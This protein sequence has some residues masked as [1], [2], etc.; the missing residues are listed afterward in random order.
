MF[1]KNKTFP[2][3]C[4]DCWWS[5]KLNAKQYGIDYNPDLPFFDQFYSFSKNVPFP[6][7]IG[8]RNIN[9]HY[10]NFSADNRN[11]YLIIESSNNED[12][13]NCYWIQLS[14]NLV[15]CSFTDHVELSYEVDDCYDCHMLFFSKSCGY[16][17]DSAFLLNCRGC[18]YC[19]GCVNLRD[20]NYRIFNKQYTKGEY[21]E[22]LASY[23]LHTYS[24]V[25]AFK[26]K[27]ENF[28]KNQPRKFAELTNIVNSTGNYLANVRN[29]RYCFHSYEAEDNA[30]SV[31][32]WRGAKNC[33]DCNT[34]G[35]AAELIYNSLNMGLQVSRVICSS[36][37]WGSKFM[38][39]CLNCPDSNDCF[40]CVG[41]V[42]GS[43]CILN[44]Q[45]TKEEYYAL[46]EKI[47]VKMKQEGIYGDFFPKHFCTS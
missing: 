25:K 36:Y 2:V 17:M 30:Y 12:C 14:K 29:S 11:C 32:V 5:D 9:S 44:K 27:F 35:R 15:D 43:Y 40:G 37:C 28:V 34:A 23:K 16:C 39:Y 41:L 42:K 8:F 7:L 46:R 26:K 6:A 20:Q 47:I 24:G 10:L 18:S 38:E 4:H 31:H 1:S 3:W 45:Y 13:I 19:L 21:E 33:M 22:K